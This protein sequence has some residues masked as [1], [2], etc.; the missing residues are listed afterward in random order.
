[1]FIYLCYCV[2]WVYHAYFAVCA[3]LSIIYELNQGI[4]QAIRKLLQNN[5][6][7]LMTLVVDNLI[8]CT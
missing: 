4:I 8:I 1:M 5:Q 2:L 6:R 3:L 7:L